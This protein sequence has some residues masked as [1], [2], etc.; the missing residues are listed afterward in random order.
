MASPHP[1]KLIFEKFENYEIID[2]HTV[3]YLLK[4]KK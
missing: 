3:R 2:E 4:L 1:M